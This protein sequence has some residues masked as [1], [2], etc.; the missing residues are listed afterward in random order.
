MCTVQISCARHSRMRGRPKFGASR[1]KICGTFTAFTDSAWKLRMALSDLI[2][3]E[4][5]TTSARCGTVPRHSI[6]P[7][8]TTTSR[9]VLVRAPCF[10]ALFATLCTDLCVLLV[11]QFSAMGYWGRG[12]CFLCSCAYA[13]M[14]LKWHTTGRRYLLCSK[15]GI[16][17]PLCLQTGIAR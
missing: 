15:I 14:Q 4:T 9:T 3:E 5:F 16:F 17:P 2:P 1:M 12:V 7:I 13:G 10:H 6:L 11:M 8:S